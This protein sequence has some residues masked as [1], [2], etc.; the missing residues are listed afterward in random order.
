VAGDQVSADPGVAVKANA[1]NATADAVAI[2]G[3]VFITLS[4]KF[5]AL[6]YFEVSLVT[7]GLLAGVV[8][9]GHLAIKSLLCCKQSKSR[10]T[11]AC[12]DVTVWSRNV[13]C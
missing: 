5:E 7:M 13:V 11:T 9:V 1:E 4:N 10:H 3:I 6:V 8:S 2:L 12:D